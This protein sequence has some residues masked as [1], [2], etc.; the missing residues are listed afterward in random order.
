[1]ARARGLTLS[2]GRAAPGLDRARRPGNRSDKV[3]V[4]LQ[5]M[6]GSRPGGP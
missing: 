3:R 2:F 1:M 6:C 5:F 4:F